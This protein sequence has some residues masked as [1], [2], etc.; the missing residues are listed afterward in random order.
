MTAPTL[1]T[2]WKDPAARAAARIPH[3]AGEFAPAPRAAEPPRARRALLLAGW[4]APDLAGTV[5]ET[6]D[7]TTTFQTSTSLSYVEDL[8]DRQ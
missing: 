8:T 1:A 4:T 5:L 7:T 6:V 3:P 2:L